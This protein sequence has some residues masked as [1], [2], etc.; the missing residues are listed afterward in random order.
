MAFFADFHTKKIPHKINKTQC[1]H[2][3][4]HCPVLWIS[5]TALFQ[6][7]S[8]ELKSFA[9]KNTSFLDKPTEKQTKN[10]RKLIML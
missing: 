7:S 10:K 8:R 2:I 3:E 1:V 6:K 5:K 4:K 9:K